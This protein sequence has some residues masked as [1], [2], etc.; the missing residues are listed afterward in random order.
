M[1]PLCEITSEVC[2]DK[3]YEFCQKAECLSRGAGS[4]L[5]RRGQPLKKGTYF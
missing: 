1:K 3:N 4:K 2:G 5:N